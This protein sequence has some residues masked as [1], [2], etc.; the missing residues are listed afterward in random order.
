M[1]LDGEARREALW[2]V[3]HEEGISAWI[4]RLKHRP[5]ASPSMAMYMLSDLERTYHREA[6]RAPRRRRRTQPNAA[7]TVILLTVFM[8]TV[9]TWFCLRRKTT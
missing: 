9:C 3:A 4:R 6:Y 5:T 8:L 2:Q 1:D 7:T